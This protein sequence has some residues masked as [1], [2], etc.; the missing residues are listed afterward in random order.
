MTLKISS[1]SETALWKERVTNHKAGTLLL[2]GSLWM[3]TED[4]WEA[5]GKRGS[6]WS[7]ALGRA[8]QKCPSLTFITPARWFP[9]SFPSIVSTDS[10][11]PPLNVSA[12]TSLTACWSGAQWA[13]FFL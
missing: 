3:H 6:L 10:I 5:G 2:S 4:G 12:S 13:E 7:P 11:H 8:V 1:S 9:C